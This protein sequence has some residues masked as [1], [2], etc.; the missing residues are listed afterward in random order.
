MKKDDFIL[1]V[2]DVV[3][4]YAEY[5]QNFDSNPQLK[6]NP[7]SLFVTLV[8]GG[9][10]LNEIANSDENIE[11]GSAL[12]GDEAVDMAENQIEQDPDF[13]PLK[14]LV[15]NGKPSK[16]AIEKIAAIYFK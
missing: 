1:N 11:I 13:Y 16:K 14:T 6:V 9:D 5:P 12:E 15:E 8:N 3:G 2:T 4:T 10:M 7:K